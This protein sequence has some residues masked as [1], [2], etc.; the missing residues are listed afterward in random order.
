MVAARQRSKPLAFGAEWRDVVAERALAQQMV[1]RWH[2]DIRI[3]LARGEGD[4]VSRG[5]GSAGSV[6]TARFGQQKI[7]LNRSRILSSY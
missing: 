6:T 4:A 5:A 1:A 2:A 7:R 3:A